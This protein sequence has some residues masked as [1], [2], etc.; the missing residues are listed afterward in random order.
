MAH[1][2]HINFFGST[3]SVED[4]SNS[5]QW[6]EALKPSCDDFAQQHY[7]LEYHK[8]RGFEL[9]DEQKTALS[10]GVVEAIKA[11]KADARAAGESWKDAWKEHFMEAVYG[12]TEEIVGD[13]N[14]QWSALHENNFDDLYQCLE[15]AMEELDCPVADAQ[16]I[17]E[18]LKEYTADKM[19]EHDFTGPMDLVEDEMIIF[20]YTPRKEGDSEY[21]SD[22]MLESNHLE[23]DGPDEHLFRL[24]TLMRVNGIDLIDDFEVDY[25]NNDAMLRWDSVLDCRFEQPSSFT[26]DHVIEVIENFGS[27]GL[28]MWIGRVSVKSLLG[29]N[30]NEP[31]QLNGGMVGAHDHING[32]GYM[33][34]MQEHTIMLDPSQSLDVETGY[35]V[36]DTHG[37]FQRSLDASIN[38]L[39]VPSK[40]LQINLN[41][42]SP[43]LQ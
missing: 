35:K 12:V 11:F 22:L 13:D 19:A 1:E 5:N 28:P 27:C 24:L 43:S 8:D 42:E 15:E 7:C 32:A 26:R 20:T 21:K 36:V 31:L 41:D 39:E 3:I 17:V 40:K 33:L 25:T 29:V 18:T 34:D 30:F 2:I 16:I 9:S 37:I 38:A 14:D 4:P 6:I 10:T 23:D